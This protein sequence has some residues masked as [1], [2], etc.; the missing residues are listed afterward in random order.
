MPY[1]PD[2]SGWPI[3][4]DLMSG[5]ATDDDVERYNRRRLERL[6][7]RE[8]HVQVIDARNADKMSSP[9]RR[10]CAE[11]NVRHRDSQTEHL[12]GVAFVTSSVAIKGILTAIYW[13]TPPPYPYK[14]FGDLDAAL[15]W[16]AARVGEARDAPS[17]AGKVPS[18]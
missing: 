9:H 16:A 5:V 2:D 8:L 7:R 12:A 15:A 17:R 1:E 13:I 11:F 10:M 3:C 14:V 4:V 6:E 18:T